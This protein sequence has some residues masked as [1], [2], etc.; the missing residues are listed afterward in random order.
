MYK[1]LDLIQIHLVIFSWIFLFSLDGGGLKGFKDSRD[2]PLISLTT[3]IFGVV[4]HPLAD[5]HIFLTQLCLTED[6]YL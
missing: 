3:A 6:T 4:H 5:L 2:K 1:V